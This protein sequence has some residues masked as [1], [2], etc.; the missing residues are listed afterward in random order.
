MD[1]VEKA[2]LWTAHIHSDEIP[3]VN[4]GVPGMEVR[5]LHYREDEQMDAVQLRAVPGCVSSMHIHH[6]PAHAFTLSG[7]WGH[8]HSFEYAPGTYVFEPIGVAHRFMAGDEPVEAFFMAY[9]D[10][11]LIDEETGEPGKS[12][13]TMARVAHYFELCEEQGLPRPNVLKV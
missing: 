8:D 11:Q 5:L 4:V 12:I 2:K 6:G 9:G 13:G 10:G 1:I 7:R 3:F